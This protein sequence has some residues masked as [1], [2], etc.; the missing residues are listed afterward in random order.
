MLKRKIKKV[1]RNQKC[2]CGSGVKHKHCECYQ[3]L[4]ASNH[5]YTLVK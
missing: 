2:P 5:N 3:I 1:G 4:Q